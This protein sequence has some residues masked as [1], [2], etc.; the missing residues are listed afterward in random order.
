MNRHELERF[1][2]DVEVYQQIVNQYREMLTRTFPAVSLRGSQC[3]EDEILRELLPGDGTYIDIGAAE[4]IQCSNTWMFYERGWRGLLVEPLFWYWPALLHHRPGDLLSDYAVRNYTGFSTLRVQGTVSS[5]LPNWN[6][7]EQG[8]ILVPCDTTANV[9]A[10]FPVIRDACR[11]CSIDVEGAEK[12]VLE[13]IDW[14]TFHPEVFVVEYREYDPVKLGADLS[15]GWAGLLEAQNYKE[16]TRTDMNI[17]YQ[18]QVPPV[19]PSPPAP[20]AEPVA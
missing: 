15:E 14:T 6:I 7:K 9:L 20:V 4:P 5:V 13:T 2:L 12:E 16:V 18:K 1:T 19:E 17:I 3:N 11:L 10:K 8:T